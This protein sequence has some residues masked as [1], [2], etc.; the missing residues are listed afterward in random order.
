MAFSRETYDHFTLWPK[1]C[2]HDIGKA[3]ETYQEGRT[4]NN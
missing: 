3:L 1:G 2:D 4:M